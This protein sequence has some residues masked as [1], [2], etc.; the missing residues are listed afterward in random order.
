MKFVRY[1]EKHYAIFD[2]NY[3]AVEMVKYLNGFEPSYKL[4]RQ[5]SQIESKIVSYQ[6]S[7]EA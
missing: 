3:A 6:M 7:F 5:D 2:Q 1:K 4:M